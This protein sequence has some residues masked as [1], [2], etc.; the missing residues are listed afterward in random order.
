MG[1]IDE[2]THTVSLMYFL[3]I[4]AGQ[5]STRYERSQFSFLKERYPS[6][7][8]FKRFYLQV[9]LRCFEGI[10]SLQDNRGT[11]GLKCDRERGEITSNIDGVG[12]LLFEERRISRFGLISRQ[13]LGDIGTP[14]FYSALILSDFDVDI[15]KSWNYEWHAGL[16]GTIAFHTALFT[17]VGLW[18]TKWND[19]LD[20]IDER[21]NF[22]LEH[23]MQPE[24]IDKWM[25]DGDFK[26]SKLYVTILQ[27]LRIFG[28]YISTVSEDLQSLDTV[29]LK[30]DNF[31]MSKMQPH[32]HRAMR[33]NWASVKEFQKQAEESL[34]GRISQKT[35]EVKSLRDGLFN[36]TSLRSAN[37][38]S[39]LAISSLEET[40]SSVSMGRYVLV[41]TVVTILYLPPSFISTV[42]G[43]D[44]FKKDDAQSKWEFKTAIVSLSLFTYLLAFVAIIAVDWDGFKHK[45]AV[46][47][48]PLMRWI[49]WP[50]QLPQS[51]GRKVEDSYA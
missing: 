9:H 11:G 10:E 36:A 12:I 29:F 41:F 42:F 19:M 7:K 46:W 28:E 18:Q 47:W 30:D 32:E 6:Q 21:I 15:D 33:S 44:M 1:A 24:E 31:P 40:K 48:K 27:I 22:R 8:N 34:L 20:K 38:S 35:E 16:E 4:F 37:I 50:S 23:T 17:S 43:L 51:F 3:G 39:E 14:P 45:C 5:W 26:R 25:F 49:Q 13:C 2:R